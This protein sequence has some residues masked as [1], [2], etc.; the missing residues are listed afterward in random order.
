MP[1][2]LPFVP[3]ATLDLVDHRWWLDLRCAC[4]RST[5]IPHK[6]LTK[7][8]GA[9][10]RVPDLLARLRCSQCG[11]SPITAG[12]IDNPAGGAFGSGYPPNRR[13]PLALPWRRGS[14]AVG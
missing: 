10:A 7:R 13:V 3:D 11:T 6:L 2:D 4:G 5:S 1:D 9:F 12:W 8:H 14:A